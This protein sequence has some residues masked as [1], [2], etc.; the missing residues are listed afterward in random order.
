M[1]WDVAAFCGVRVLTYTVMSNH[2]HVLLEVPLARP[3][4][5]EEL[6]GRYRRLYGPSGNRFCPKPEVLAQILAQ[7]GVEAE[8]WRRRL[9]ARMGDVSEFMKTLKQRF[10]IWYNQTHGR[11]GTLWS[12]RFTSV[13]VEGS[14][15]ALSAV[16]AYIDLNA[17]RAGLVKDPGDYRWCGYTECLGGKKRAREGLQAAFPSRPGADPGEILAAYRILLYGEGGTPRT[18]KATLDPDR[19]RR[20]LEAQGT[21]PL[22]V[23]LRCRMRFMTYGAIIGSKAFVAEQAAAWRGREKPPRGLVGSD[24]GDLAVSR[25]NP[26]VVIPGGEE[27]A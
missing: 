23:I 21:L 25:G 13:L 4:G 10:S 2:F 1:L 12:E 26:T 11:F 7:G 19:V 20:V 9:E 18:G 14:T 24:W 27:T 8:R 5:D 17:V 6:T 15:R 22:A 3:L 16:A